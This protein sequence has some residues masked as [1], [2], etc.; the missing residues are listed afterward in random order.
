MAIAT[1]ITNANLGTLQE[2][3]AVLRSRLGRLRLRLQLQMALEFAL[4]AAAVIVATAA[5]L[6]FLDWWF[7]L[8][9][10]ARVV[11]LTIALL[12]VVPY[13]L[14]RAW[15]RWAATRLD[16]LSLAMTLDRFRPGI[17]GRI[18]DVLQLPD[19]LGEPESTVSPAMIRLAVRQAS[20][21]LA[22]SDWATLWNL[23][24]TTT[25][26]MALLVALLVPNNF[27][28]FAPSAARLSARSVAA[29]LLGAMA[30]PYLPDSDR[31]GH[32]E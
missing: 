4:D 18:A 23:R 2:E 3:Q 31:L 15:R 16:D 10:T 22:A 24:R 32:S 5:V 19:Q 26:I 29:W 20:E 25:R 8:G 30:A 13:A 28:L 27:A 9:V 12:A 1:E 7:R 17:G 14:T 11:L 6:V 21:A